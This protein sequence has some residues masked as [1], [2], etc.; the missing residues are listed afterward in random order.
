M[1]RAALT[2]VGMSCP[3]KNGRTK[4]T[5]LI[6]NKVSKKLSMVDGLKLY[7]SMGMAEAKVAPWMFCADFYGVWVDGIIRRAIKKADWCNLL[8]YE[9]AKKCKKVRIS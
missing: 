6:L 4:T 3:P 7:S 8:F 5:R 2:V 9:N 1:H